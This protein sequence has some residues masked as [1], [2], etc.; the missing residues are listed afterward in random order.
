MG[1]NDWWH[2]VKTAPRELMAK[3]LSDPEW[4][5]GKIANYVRLRRPTRITLMV[6]GSIIATIGFVFPWYIVSFDP[7]GG[8]L[9]YDHVA[10][11]ASHDL[12]NGLVM[13]T[14]A[15]E[16]HDSLTADGL[17]YL[18]WAI[19]LT[20]INGLFLQIFNPQ[21]GSFKSTVAKRIT[22][23]ILSAAH[24]TAIL[25]FIKD[26]W[27]ANVDGGYQVSIKENVFVSNGK[28]DFA[29][30][31]ARSI[32]AFPLGGFFITMAGVAISAIGLY[33]GTRIMTEVQ[34]AARREVHKKV[35]GGVGKLV[36]TAVGLVLLGL[37]I[38]L[39]FHENHIRVSK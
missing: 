32:T 4:V 2:R 1:L 31:A 20:F 24:L 37:P 19:A 21:I 34:L 36:S 17:K 35:L 3:D 39:F 10:H 29:L 13:M 30:A 16:A 12:V 5:T 25:L 33:S 9:V 18:E 38:Y 23:I 14:N 7:P 11:H 28:G 26:E 8:V 15:R 27:W 6:V 22:S